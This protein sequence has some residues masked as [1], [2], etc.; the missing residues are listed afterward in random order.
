MAALKAS[1]SGGR[2]AGAAAPP[3]ARHTRLAKSLTA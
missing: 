1:W 2:R 3:F